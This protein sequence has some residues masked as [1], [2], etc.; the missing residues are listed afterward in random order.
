M[1]R[2]SPLQLAVLMLCA[3]CFS[4]MTYFPYTGSNTLVFMFAILVSTALQ[5]LLLVPAA[6]LC[7]NR[8]KGLCEIA[9]ERSR[10]LGLLVTG[11]FFVYFLWDIF[12]TTGTFAYF[13]DNYFSNYISRVPAIICAGAAAIYLGGLGSSALGKCGGAM[14]FLFCVFTGVLL[15]STFTKPELANFHLALPN[16]PKALSGGISGEFVR[17]RE[18]VMLVFLL[19]DV[20]GSKPNAVYS[21]LAVKLVILELLLGFVTLVLGDFALAT[22]TPFFYLSCL[23]NSSVIERYDA[24]FMAVW[25]VL[26]VVRLAAVLHCSVRC[27]RLLDRR[28][29]RATAIA[30]GQIIPAAATFYLL[31]KRS[32]KG[33]AYLGESP[34][35]ITAAAGVVPMIVLLA[36]NVR[37]EKK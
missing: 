22:D 3:R 4:M 12:I 34:F 28:I 9:L 23:S 25:T 35:L 24:G 17:N 7:A 20:K 21:Y 37:R 5:G 2:L 31:S 11:A 14:F 27:L 1:N 36:V 6:V 26:A 32:W 15:L 33:L 18:L 29:T 16:V 10:V 8:E 13:M 30:V 19:G